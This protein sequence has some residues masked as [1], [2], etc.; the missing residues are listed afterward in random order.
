MTEVEQ[1]F[2]RAGVSVRALPPDRAA[3]LAV[4][5]HVHAPWLHLFEAGRADRPLFYYT[6]APLPFDGATFAAVLQ[7]AAPV[8]HERARGHALFDDFLAASEHVLDPAVALGLFLFGFFRQCPDA[9]EPAYIQAVRGLP[10]Q[11]VM[12]EKVRAAVAELYES[13]RFTREAFAELAARWM[14]RE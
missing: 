6:R 4:L 9:R 11:R 5:A 10:A 8:L 12:T 7:R 13:G 3:T 14:N 1:Y 2:L